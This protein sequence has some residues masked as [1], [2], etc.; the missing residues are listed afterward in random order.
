MQRPGVDRI[1]LLFFH[2]VIPFESVR[3][4]LVLLSIAG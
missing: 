4:F 3:F 2:G 1:I